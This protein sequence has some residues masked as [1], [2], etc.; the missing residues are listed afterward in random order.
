MCKSHAHR[1]VL[2]TWKSYLDEELESH[3]DEVTELHGMLRIVVASNGCMRVPAVSGE[4]QQL[5]LAPYQWDR[6]DHCFVVRIFEF[7]VLYICVAVISVYLSN[8][9]LN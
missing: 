6:F 8:L 1:S 2:N 4:I 5:H 9:L 3:G 7:P